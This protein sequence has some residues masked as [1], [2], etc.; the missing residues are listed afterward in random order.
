MIFYIQPPKAAGK[1]RVAEN[2]HELLTPSASDRGL[3]EDI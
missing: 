1:K 2:I 3:V